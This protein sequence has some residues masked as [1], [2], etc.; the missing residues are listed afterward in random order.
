MKPTGVILL[1]ITISFVC[2]SSLKAAVFTV[3][4]KADSGPGTL[5]D[6]ITKANSNGTTVRDYIYFNLPG[7]TPADVTITVLTNLPALSSNI[8]IDGGTQTSN[9]LGFSSAR[10]ILN[11]PAYTPSP[12]FYGLKIESAQQVEIYGLAIKSAVSQGSG[13]QFIGACSDIIIGGSGKGNVI[14]GFS[15]GISGYSN[16]LTE[17]KT[18]LT[19]QSNFIG[20]EEDGTTATFNRSCTQ[21][22]L[23][24]YLNGINLGGNRPELG[25]VLMGRDVGISL[26]MEGGNALVSYN[27][28]GTDR[29]GMGVMNFNITDGPMIGIY[30]N[31]TGNILVSD[32]QIA[33][34]SPEGLRL[35]DIQTGTFRVVRNKFGTDASGANLLGERSSAI[36]VAD[37]GAGVIGGTLSDKNIIAGSLDAP[38]V[39]T[40]SY[41]ITVSQNEMFCNNTNTAKTDPAA[42]ILHGNWASPDGRPK[43]F[44]FVTACNTTSLSG[45]ATPNAKMEAFTAYRCSK[46]SKCDGRNYIETFFAG[47]D[48]KWT[49]NLKGRDGVI[50][51]ATDA[52][53]ATSDYSN[54]F[55]STDIINNITNTA[56]GK[57]TGSIK[58]KI[59]Y[60]AMPFHWEDDAGNTVG[61][62]T[63]LINVKAGRYR[64]AM[65][66]AGCN[67][68]ECIVYSPFF[69]VQDKSPQV[70]AG[71]GTITPA[72]CGNNNGSITDLR[73]LGLN[74][75]Y[76]WRN[77]ANQVISN[78][79][80]VSNLSPGTYTL[81]VSD[82][83]NGCSAVGGPYVIKAITAP[84]LDATSLVL[85]D[86]ICSQPTGSISGLKVTGTGTITYSWKNAAG[87]V[88]GN[89][90]NLL[91]VPAGQYTLTFSDASNCTAAPAGPYTVSA[92]G[93][94]TIDKSG[95]VVKE[96]DCAVANGSITG[97]KA[98][99]A[100]TIRW[101][102]KNGIQVATGL[103]LIN[104]GAGQYTLQITNATG[105]SASENFIVPQHLPAKLEV[106][107]ANTK[108]PVC[109]QQNGSI[110]G[111]V[112]TGGTPV[113][114][115]WVDQTGTVV[116]NEKDLLDRGDGTYRLYVVDIEQCE[117]VVTAFTLRTPN[118]PVI[119][120]KYATII[121]DIC[122][123]ISGMVGGLTVDGVHPMA[124][125][126][127]NQ[128]SVVVSTEI[129]A[130]GLPGGQYTLKVTDG[131]GC[132]K[133]SSAFPVELVD[134]LLLAPTMKDATI[135]DGMIA[136]LKVTN[137]HQGKYRLQEQGSE[138]AQVNTTG[139]FTISGLQKTTTYTLNY[140]FGDCVSP[141]TYVTVHV[142][143]AIRVVAPTAFSPNGDG[144][145]DIFKLKGFG[146]ASYTNFSIMDRW[147][148]LVF[149]T[150]DI[151]KG[152]DGS[153]RGKMVEAGGYIWMMQ[154]IDILGQPVQAKGA[155]LVCY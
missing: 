82:T 4:S 93:I 75:K 49:Y 96:T 58:N 107:Q 48:G 61:T 128:D 70:V 129:K 136:N 16:N 131:N 147:G 54:P 90:L 108:N 44:V 12:D 127:L 154:G 27:T 122:N 133:Y 53:G 5:R 51:S 101:L 41:K 76:E 141:T 13:I 119:D 32:N 71:S 19:I 59:L 7:A 140:E 29:T 95:I 81:T 40:N 89:T 22:I 151:E 30:G 124:Y 63:S 31:T 112:L 142:I 77:A 67:K 10:V 50:L 109:N 91:N 55:W 66:G 73:F 43:P 137:L 28:I 98:T 110:T 103:D 139:E 144:R 60:N 135:M 94:I 97:L 69:E 80:T 11:R 46:G 26:T 33:G 1:L 115:R 83:I 62:D 18:N 34:R 23:L 84:V 153:F 88:V 117:Q 6:A 149:N 155:V 3:T 45:T 121:D 65:Y 68:P 64:L 130:Q 152:W 114:Y 20:F 102:D 15:N 47:A 57:S 104:K 138:N 100:Q 14:N 56:C 111:L 116:G 125:A 9:Y 24:N 72:T 106:A 99:N 105:C 92:P 87:Q 8:V 145:N 113:S 120:E 35:E 37:C 17:I 79:T 85:K 25:N 146:V 132:I 118:M 148:N 36:V 150:K 86:A 21:A 2:V 123:T 78:A 126:W 52:A 143:D 134:I 42:S 39:I 74:L 38:V